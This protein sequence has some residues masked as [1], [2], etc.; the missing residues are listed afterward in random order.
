MPTAQ[1][2]RE[3]LFNVN[4]PIELPTKEFEDD[5]WPLIS[6]A[7]TCN[8][9]PKPTPIGAPLGYIRNYSCRLAAK[10]NPKPKDTS[11]DTPDTKRRKRT[12]RVPCE[13]QAA[14]KI[15]HVTATGITTVERNHYDTPAIHT[16]SLADVDKVR[17]PAAIKTLIG[18]ETLKSNSPLETIASI[19]QLAEESGL[20]EVAAFVTRTE[21]VNTR[22]KQRQTD[23][24]PLVGDV[25]VDGEVRSA[26]ELLVTKGYQW[27][28]FGGTTASVL[29]GVIPLFNI[30]NGGL[31]SSSSSSSNN[32]TNTNSGIADPAQGLVF[33]RSQQ[34]AKMSTHGWLTLIG[35]VEDT[36]KHGWKLFTL[37]VRDCLGCWDSGAHFFVSDTNSST[38]AQ[39]L[40]LVRQLAPSWQP[41]YMLTDRSPAVTAGI[42]I[43]FP[44]ATHGE[45]QAD[46]QECKVIFSATHTMQVWERSITAPQTRQMMVQALHCRTRLG[47]EHMIEKALSGCNNQETK[48]HIKDCIVSTDRWALFARQESPFLLQAASLSI[49]DAYHHEVK[50][51]SSVTRG[52]I[53][54]SRAVMELDDINTELALKARTASCTNES[55]RIDDIRSPLLSHIK[56]FP[57]TV[58]TLLVDEARAMNA[59]IAKGKRPPGLKHLRCGCDFFN[60]Y[61]LPCRHI[62]HMALFGDLSSGKEPSFLSDA[63]WMLFQDMFTKKE[64]LDVYRTRNPVARNGHEVVEK[65]AEEGGK[66]EVDRLKMEELFER[67]QRLYQDL[68]D[69]SDQK[70]LEALVADLEA[71]SSRQP[72]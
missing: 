53:G 65:T 67:S 28:S 46:Q 47:F 25:H 33:A 69:R 50:R 8:S 42:E 68:A 54:T 38:I 63:D 15:T 12:S 39:A 57:Y 19:R 70:G 40:Q 62:L 59:R 48:Q 61:L 22:R 6:N 24:K 17:R 44:K 1:E 71:F 21:L 18:K 16:H 51:L 52:L 31:G 5:W 55:T 35:S 60:K 14:I 37:F 20:G 66:E 34:L 58:Q 49:L 2:K 11:N 30:N 64:G 13:C 9:G 27:L 26:A 36:N 72:F 4:I 29:T 43:T 7:W 41:R 56:H 23:L 45:Q 32:N 10:Y 3:L